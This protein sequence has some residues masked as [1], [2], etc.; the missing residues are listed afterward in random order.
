MKNRSTTRSPFLVGNVATRMSTELPLKFTFIR[1]SCGRRFSVMSRLHTSLIRDIIICATRRSNSVKSVITPSIRILTRRFLLL[2]SI[3]RSEASLEIA[4][5]R[6]VL[7][8]R[9]IGASFSSCAES[10]ISAVFTKSVSE[11]YSST[12]EK[13]SVSRRLAV[14]FF[15]ASTEFVG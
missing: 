3:W 11:I 8:N 2:G 13:I 4:A 7:N 1:P 6:R 9:T 5:D 10:A 14:E 15:S 12:S